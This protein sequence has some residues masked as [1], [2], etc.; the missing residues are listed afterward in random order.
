MPGRCTTRSRHGRRA[1]LFAAVSLLSGCGSLLT[2]G[3][4]ATPL[5]AIM[6]ASSLGSLLALGLVKRG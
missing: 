3:T 5:L 4:G 2:E 6:A 1:F